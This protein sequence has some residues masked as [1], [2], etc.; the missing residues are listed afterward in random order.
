ML[1]PLS[2]SPPLATL[3]RTHLCFEVTGGEEALVLACLGGH[4]CQR[5]CVSVC[6]CV[7]MCVAMVER[8]TSGG[9]LRK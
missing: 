9:T 6:Y 5:V 7:E 8:G 3:P 2:V 1:I 4:Y